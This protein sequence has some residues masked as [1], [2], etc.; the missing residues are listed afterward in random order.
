MPLDRMRAEIRVRHY[1]IRTVQKLLG[2][3]GAQ[4]TLIYTR[5]G[6]K[7]VVSPLGR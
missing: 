3:R 2:H 4:T 7:T 5:V 6:G 1:S